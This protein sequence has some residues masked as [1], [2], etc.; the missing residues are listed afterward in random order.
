MPPTHPPALPAPGRLNHVAYVMRDAEETCNFYRGVLGLP[1]V[2]FVIDDKVPSTGDEFPY[3]HVFFQLGDGS[4]VAFFESL[5]LP[6]PS[7]SAHPAYDI[8]NH[9]ALDVG[10]PEAVDRWAAHLR[11]HDV[12][13]LGPVDHGVIYSIYFHDPNG[14]RLELTANTNWAPD[15]QASE[16]VLLDWTAAKRASVHQNDFAPL[17]ELIAKRRAAHK[18]EKPLRHT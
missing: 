7:P 14:I 3:A 13:V 12:D 6:A 1:L 5:G 15:V 4:T 10:E 9:L 8:F 2:E 16:K 17:R 11:S 18:I